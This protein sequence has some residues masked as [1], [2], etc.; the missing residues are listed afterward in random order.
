MKWM[1]PASDSELW[2]MRSREAL[3]RIRNRAGVPSR[4]ANTRRSGN[5]SGAA[6]DF[7]DDHKPARRLEGEAGI[8]QAFDLAGIRQ[9]QVRQAGVERQNPGGGELPGQGGLAGLPGSQ[10]SHHWRVTNREPD[11]ICKLFS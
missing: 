5:R 9:V 10:Q 6:L 3:P 1:R 2:R 11:P 4:S 8:H 7:V